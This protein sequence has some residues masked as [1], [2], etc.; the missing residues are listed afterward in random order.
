MVE[1]AAP[2]A[3]AARAG[4]AALDAKPVTFA[5]DMEIRQVGDAPRLPSRRSTIYFEIAGLAH[6]RV[7]DSPYQRGYRHIGAN[8]Y[9]AVRQ[10]GDR[11][12]LGRAQNRDVAGQVSVWPCEQH[13][14]DGNRT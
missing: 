2:P 4:S 8:Q 10:R 14:P 1:Q 11:P 5:H 6:G 12:A 3:V 13:Y 7:G 9:D